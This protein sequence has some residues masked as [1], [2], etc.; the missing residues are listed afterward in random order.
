MFIYVYLICANSC[1]LHIINAAYYQLNCILL[2]MDGYGYKTFVL[3]MKK[4]ATICGALNYMRH[5]F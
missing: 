4:S 3:V 5:I 1:I 2:E